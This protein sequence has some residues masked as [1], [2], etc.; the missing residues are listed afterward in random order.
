MELYKSDNGIN[1]IGAVLTLV[2]AIV[3]GAVLGLIVYFVSQFIYLICI[4]PFLIG[5][6][7]GYLLTLGVD[8]GKVRSGVYVAIAGI[9][10]AL[11]FLAASRYPTYAIDFK[12]DVRDELEDFAGAGVEVTD[13]EVN[14]FADF[15][16]EAETGATGYWGFLQLEAKEGISIGRRSTDLMTLDGT[17]AWVYWAIDFLIIAGFG[18]I[19][20]VGRTD[21][22]YSTLAK[23]WYRQDGFIGTLPMGE[24][25][26]FMR[27]LTESRYEDAGQKLSG[28]RQAPTPKIDVYTMRSSDPTDNVILAF[29]EVTV[30]NKG[31]LKTDTNNN[32]GVI[33]ESDLRRLGGSAEAG[34][35]F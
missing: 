30:D 9:I 34:Q 12:S 10:G 29:K 4:F 16:L 21:E 6:I 1:P 2:L 32:Y 3:G 22:P 20:G 5:G 8:L 33:T 31:N 28:E 23:E 18:I 13:E 7:F 19:L 24:F 26:E 11:V 35:S 17:M 27:S 15:I 25:P 14:E